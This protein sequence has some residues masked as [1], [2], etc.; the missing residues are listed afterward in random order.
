MSR[1]GRICEQN[2]VTIMSASNDGSG[3]PL[4]LRSAMKNDESDN[5]KTP[6]ASGTLKGT[7]SSAMQRDRMNLNGA[8][9]LGQCNVGLR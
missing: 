3:G 5:D 9:V 2:I 8:G 4:P 7:C 6:P 1:V